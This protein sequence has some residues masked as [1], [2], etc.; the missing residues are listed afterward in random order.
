MDIDFKDIRFCY[1]LKNDL[2]I[3]ML[4]KDKKQDYNNDNLIET[5]L[6]IHQLDLKGDLADNL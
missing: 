6:Y 2:I 3:E 1:G 5:R 4:E